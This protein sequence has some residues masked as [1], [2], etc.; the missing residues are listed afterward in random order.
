MDEAIR[1][2]QEFEAKRRREED[3]QAEIC[4]I[5]GLIVEARYFYNR[6]LLIDDYCRQWFGKIA[7]ALSDDTIG[8]VF[9]AIAQQSD[10]RETGIRATSVKLLLEIKSGRVAE[11][12]DSL[13][14]VESDDLK[15]AIRAGMNPIWN[16]VSR[17][18][19]PP[20]V[21]H[22]IAGNEPPAAS[23]EPPPDEESKPAD[24]VPLS[25]TEI[26]RATGYPVRH[27]SRMLE[28]GI[29]NH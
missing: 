12:A 2:W 8:E 22:P 28:A 27:V 13:L 15:G 7:E 25:T 5:Q 17:T 6:S 19:W 3:A 23:C 4:R 9:D 21:P 29:I 1:E 26:A 24:L 16:A 14:A 11:A 10:M 20:N 18:F